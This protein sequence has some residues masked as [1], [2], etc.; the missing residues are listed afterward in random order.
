MAQN[1][2]IFLKHLPLH[3][4][5]LFNPIQGGGSEHILFRGVRAILHIPTN[6]WTTGGTKLKIYIVID[7]HKLF[8]KI[9]KKLG[10]KC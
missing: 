5:S 3:Y 9:E 4:L 6:F 8:S 10:W 7:I 1:W 2:E